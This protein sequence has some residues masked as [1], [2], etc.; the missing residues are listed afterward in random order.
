MICPLCGATFSD[1]RKFCGD[2]GS[3]LPWRC[4]ACA[5]DNAPGNRFCGE[6]GAPARSLERRVAAGKDR[7]S[8]AERRQLTV[9]FADLVDSTLLSTRLDPEDLRTVTAAYHE[10]VT[11]LAVRLGGFIA[12]YMG[13]G[14]L[15]YFGYP[16]A[17][18]DDAERAVRAGLAIVKA[19]SH[20]G[21][22]AGP[23]GAL[24]ARVGIA[25]GVVVVGELIG[26][27]AA[28]ETAAVGEV[29]NLAAR[30]QAV[31]EPNTVVI[32]ESTRRLTGGLFNYR[33]LD[34]AD[35]KGFGAVRAWSV[36]G[37]GIAESRFEALRSEQ[38]PLVGREE[39]LTLLLRRWE[40][41]RAGE[42][43]AVLISGEP[44]IGKSRL[45]AA[46]E[47]KIGRAHVRLLCSPLHQDT[48]LHPIIRHLERVAGFHDGDAV[49]SKFAK[50]QRLLKVRD[51]TDAEVTL[52]A[53]LLSIADA[54]V[55]PSLTP[56]Q[57]RQ[58]IFA[59]LLRYIG[60]SAALEPLL[61]LAEDM[62][63]ADPTTREL[64]EV[65]VQA[66][67]PARMLLI[68][69]T[70]PEWQASWATLPQAT[71]QVLGGLRRRDA[72][73]LAKEII[74]DHVLRVE[75]L[76]QII[77]QAD[78]VPLFI[79]ELTKT[80]LESL[81][82]FGVQHR[83]AP[84][85]PDFVI[86]NSLQAALM[87]RLDRLAESKKVA[88]L[89][90]VIGREFS[91]ALLSALSETP[92]KA[93]EDALAQLV[94]SGLATMRGLPPESTYSFKHALVQETAYASLL[95]DQRRALHLRLAEILEK[96]GIGSAAAAPEQIAWH[97]AEAGVADKSI[98]YYLKAAECATGRFAL[99]EMVSQIQKALQQVGY[100]DETATK[101]R[102]ELELQVALGQVLIDYRGSGSAEVRSAFERARELCL[103]LGDIPTLVVVFDGLALNHHFGHSETKDILRYTTELLD[104]AKQDPLALLCARRA[105]SAVNLLHGRFEEAR[106]E[107]QLV[108]ETYRSQG[109]DPAYR[110]MARDPRVSTYTLLGICL[111]LLGRPSAGAAMSMEGLQH[112]EAVGHVISLNTALRRSCLQAILE[113]DVRRVVGLSERLLLLNR[114]H[115]TF[116]GQREGTI[117][118][119]WAQLRERWDQNLSQR[120]Q[121]CLSELDAAK[122]WVLLPFLMLAIAEV[123]GQHGET[124]SCEVLLNRATELIELTG[125]QWCEAEAMRLRACH[126][127]GDKDVRR[128]LLQQSLARATDQGARLW[129]LRVATS[130][131]KALHEE[132]R[133]AG[134][135]ETLAAIHSGFL[136]EGDVPDVVE[137][138]QVLKLL[139]TA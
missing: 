96:S 2:C 25:S 131:A 58:M 114:R 1:G 99:A 52:L 75:L 34:L 110:K 36:L 79:E 135:S 60:N 10:T 35:L 12:R 88:Q 94:A 33:E 101:L 8:R 45:V 126:V 84:L 81:G 49:S 5:S 53:D 67:E 104:I 7:G 112:A 107:M 129:E 18:E 32:A 27:G 120:V 41:A 30:L 132:G 90:S 106:C 40:Q 138:R 89:G 83:A 85:S 72:L 134:A 39:Q 13:D 17:S 108:I 124:G 22:I 127:T 105:R 137:A 24:H 76:D 11:A 97:F 65:Q 55:E 130:L 38:L 19:T 133:S 86:P 31:A 102:K 111:T 80:V 3:P 122:H 91:F 73:T 116:V 121:A 14:V 117:F 63:W 4:E 70:R 115:E 125:E 16:R 6:C 20:L 118:Q 128:R 68:A 66:I 95:R 136:D 82:F 48:F 23:P 15:V 37:E 26:S 71:V 43:Q 29:P 62:H 103:A 44:G 74:S 87:A 119:G 139:G 109:Q 54:P 57:R 61:I 28:L 50:L 64:L 77:V 9:L 47:H 93:L 113:R 46:L 56:P 21:T 51:L 98:A 78:G 59:A 100:L 123:S 92:A 42:G 69:T